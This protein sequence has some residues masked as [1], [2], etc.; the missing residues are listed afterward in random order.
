[1]KTPPFAKTLRAACSL[2]VLA[3]LFYVQKAGAQITFSL[4]GQNNFVITCSNPTLGISAIGN[5]TA[6]VTYTLVSAQQATVSAGSTCSVSSPGNYTL[7]VESGSQI[8]IGR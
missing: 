5:F 7:Y 2:S 3:L 6:P 4:N 8:K 1:M